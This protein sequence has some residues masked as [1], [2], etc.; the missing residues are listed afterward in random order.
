MGAAL[1]MLGMMAL[2]AGMQVPGMMA[3]RKAEKR[4]GHMQREQAGRIG[5]A[6]RMAKGGPLSAANLAELGKYREQFRAGQAERGIFSSGVAAGQEGEVMPQIEQRLREAQVRQ[7]LDIAGGYDP[8]LASQASRV[9]GGG[10]GGAGGIMM[11]MGMEGLLGQSMTPRPGA[12]TMGSTSG[13][14]QWQQDYIRQQRMGY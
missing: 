10:G 9:A 2:G 5:E 3:Q 4:L 12:T 13:L 7:L 14:P 8:I 11:G 1:P 6:E